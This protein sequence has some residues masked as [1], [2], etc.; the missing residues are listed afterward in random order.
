MSEALRRAVQARVAVGLGVVAVLGLGAAPA[1][2]ATPA[3]YSNNTAIG[4]SS[5]Q[6]FTPY[7]STINVSGAP[8]TAGTVTVNLRRIVH[9]KPADLH[10]LVVDPA[11]RG[12]VLMAGCFDTSP[13]SDYTMTFQDA[14]APCG[15]GRPATGTYAPTNRDPGYVFPAPA[16]AG[17]YG[18]TLS[19]LAADPANGTWSLYVT[20]GVG[21]D[22]GAIQEGWTLTVAGAG[23]ALPTVPEA[24]AAALLLVAGLGAAAFVGVRRHQTF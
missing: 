12:V 13:A 15:T 11:G 21:K 14:A 9:T 19:T 20:N 8:A 4:A 24:P 22:S 18:A 2:A 23:G 3:T 7:P 10:V 6:V 5:N 17:P 1:L 16:P